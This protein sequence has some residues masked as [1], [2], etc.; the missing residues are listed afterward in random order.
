[1][2]QL[3]S[4][5]SAGAFSFKRRENSNS[6]KLISQISPNIKLKT[7]QKMLSMFCSGDPG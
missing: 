4:S 3:C 6:R 2:C 5:C 7:G 1:M